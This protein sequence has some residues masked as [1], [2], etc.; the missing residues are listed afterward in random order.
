M[1]TLRDL[2]VDDTVIVSDSNLRTRHSRQIVSKVGRKY[3]TVGHDQFEIDG[4]FAT[5]RSYGGGRHAYTV[6]AWERLEL[7]SKYREAVREY[8]EA[9]R[10][11]RS[12]NLTDDDLREGISNLQALLQKV[13]PLKAG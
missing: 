4:G 13:A 7:E 5:M 8:G 6:E 1:R 12:L 10:W 9:V 2:K 11:S 3:L